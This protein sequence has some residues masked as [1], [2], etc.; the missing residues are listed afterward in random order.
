MG[1]C[2]SA[3]F[4]D[5]GVDCLIMNICTED[6]LGGERQSPP[7][8]KT[9]MPSATHKRSDSLSSWLLSHS[10]N[11]W[12][13]GITWPSL[14][15]SGNWGSGNKCKKRLTL[16]LLLLLRALKSSVSDPEAQHLLPTS[17]KLRQSN[18]LASNP[19]QF[20]YKLFLKIDV[21][22]NLFLTCCNATMCQNSKLLF[23]TYKHGFIQLASIWN[24]NH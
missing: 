16:W 2:V 7:A 12:C 3:H 13:E 9:G 20:C 5:R 10:L 8:Q 18:L 4:M 17:M 21:L 22:G 14:S 11:H 6:N 24:C 15:P 23:K 1:L 19:S